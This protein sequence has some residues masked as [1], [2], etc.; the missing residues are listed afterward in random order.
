MIDLKEPDLTPVSERTRLKKQQELEKFD[1]DHYLEDFFDENEAI[2][3]FLKYKPEFH[4]SDK[5]SIEYTEK[6]IDC[7]KSLPKK[8][9]LLDKQEKFYA[10]TSLI[11]ILYAYCFNNRINCG[12][13]NVESGWTIAKLSSTLSWLDVFTYKFI[14]FYF[15][16]QHDKLF[17]YNR[18]LNR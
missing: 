9:Y 18:L 6:E 3:E 10:F 7:L 8:T 11:D 14:F 12:E 2:D 1:A 13:K 5:N 4:D 16:N 15:K 17:I